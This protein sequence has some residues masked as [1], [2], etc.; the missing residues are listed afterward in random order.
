[1]HLLSLLADCVKCWDPLW[2]NIAIPDD[3]PRR[4][5]VVITQ[6]RRGLATKNKNYKIA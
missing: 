4:I 5:K 3:R 1:M 2:V 6:Q